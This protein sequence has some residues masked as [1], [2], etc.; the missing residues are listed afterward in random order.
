MANVFVKAKMV[1]NV[2][3]NVSVMKKGIALVLVTN[4]Q[5]ILATVIAN[6]KQLH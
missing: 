6:L 2:L 3:A 5:W 1:K 4:K